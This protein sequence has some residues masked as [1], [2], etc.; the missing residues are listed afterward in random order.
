MIE[1]DFRSPRIVDKELECPTCG[2]RAEV[3]VQAEGP[4]RMV[5]IRPIADAL[6]PDDSTWHLQEEKPSQKRSRAKIKT[7][8]EK[9]DLLKQKF[10]LRENLSKVKERIHKSASWGYNWFKKLVDW[11]IPL[12]L[13]IT[14]ITWAG[15]MVEFSFITKQYILPSEK[16]PELRLIAI[17]HRKFNEDSKQ[18]EALPVEYY[19]G[20]ETAEGTF[21]RQYGEAKGACIR[22]EF[23]DQEG[24]FLSVRDTVVTVTS[25]QVFTPT[26]IIKQNLPNPIEQPKLPGLK[27]WKERGDIFTGCKVQLHVMLFLPDKK[28]ILAKQEAWEN[29]Y[30]ATKNELELSKTQNKEQ[31][32]ADERKIAE[33]EKKSLEIAN[34]AKRF[35]MPNS[36]GFPA[37]EFPNSEGDGKC[38][39]AAPFD[40]LGMRFAQSQPM[41]IYTESEFNRRRG[42]NKTQNLPPLEEWQKGGWNVQRCTVAGR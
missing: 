14:V 34:L 39:T 3:Q 42:L 38:Y 41:I 30:N 28:D 10:S 20:Y 31:K 15:K 40:K 9:V 21:L 25:V 37:Y 22:G 36:T 13:G 17:Q 16:D 5:N 27:E 6:N 24:V 29:A 2:N 35:L 1:E 23:N 33:A 7:L 19:H 11:G 8:K 32:D 12:G 18:Y 26:E 4:I